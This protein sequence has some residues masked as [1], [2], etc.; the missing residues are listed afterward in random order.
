MHIPEITTAH[1]DDGRYVEIPADAVR[2]WQYEAHNLNTQLGLAAWYLS[3]EENEDKVKGEAEDDA[4]C[5]HEERSHRVTNQSQT[6]EYQ[7]DKPMSSVR[8][9]GRRACVLD[10]LA[11]VERG[12]GEPA[13]WQA[14]HQGFRFDVPEDIMAAT[15]RP[16]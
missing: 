9:C 14:P 10:A 4:R 11:F 8:V 5:D 7:D 13:A 12:T 2:D 3:D 15:T 6:G 1:L 16:L